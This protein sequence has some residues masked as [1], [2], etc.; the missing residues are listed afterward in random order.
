MATEKSTVRP[1][2]PTIND[3]LLTRESWKIFQIMAEFVEGFERLVHIRPSVSIFGSARTLSGHDYY[4]QAEEIGEKLSN[5]GYSVVTGGGPGLM[6]GVNKGAYKGTSTSVGLNITLPSNEITNR[7]QDISLRFRHFFTRKVMF[8]KYAA[9][10]VILPGGFGTL[11]EFAEILALIQTNKTRRIPVIL[12]NEPFWRDLIRWFKNT[13]IVQ[14]M[15]DESD[16]EFFKIVN[17]P[18]E[19]VSAIRRFYKQEPSDTDVPLVGEL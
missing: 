4:K 6:E 14:G 1:T 18:D 2:V 12:V 7:Y 10:Y 19:V 3:S 11:D 5:A 16:L 17:E 8:V 15:I 13:L 9:A